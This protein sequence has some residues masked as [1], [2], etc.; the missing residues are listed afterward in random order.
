MPP[1]LLVSQRAESDLVQIWIYTYRHWGSTQ[2]DHYH[3][4]LHTT[5]QHCTRHP[6]AGRAR[7]ELRRGY[8]SIRTGKHVVF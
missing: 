2:A 8:R 4:L 3:D 6:D 1:K 5:L 7:D